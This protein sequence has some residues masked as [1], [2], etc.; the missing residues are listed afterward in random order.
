MHD[1]MG[2]SPE[3]VSFENL[4]GDT[5]LSYL[6]WLED[7]RKCSATTRNLRKTAISS[8]AKYAM[9]KNLGE[10]I[11]FYT[12][13]SDIPRK[14]TQ[15][16]PDIKYFTKEEVSILLD[17]PNTSTKIGRRN[18]VLMS[19]L[20]ASGARAQELCDITLNDVYFGS[21]TNIRLIGKGNKPRL[22]TIPSN[23]ASLLKKYLTNIG[24][25]AAN[26]N[27]Q[28]RHIFSSQTNDKMSP[29]CVG[30]IV[31]KYVGIVKA[32]H[33]HLFWRNKY[34]PHS[35]RHSIAVHMLECGE[36]LA[37]IKAFLGH[38]S[39]TS[40][41]I[42]ANVTPELAN[43]YLRERGKAIPEINVQ[44]RGSFTSLPF[45]NRAVKRPSSD[46]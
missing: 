38:A 30:E 1:K 11:A 45:L 35:F 5:V 20:Y 36:S 17:A 34:S 9:K 42:Y 25:D 16:E 18:A 29:S 3:K 46:S 24:L 32:S 28:R 26:P 39:I 8:F 13:V 21:E 40:T 41:T 31:K 37:V 23:C 44:Q 15:T 7:E 22:V 6:S 2:L 19:V 10:A 12:E 14:R 33:P 4:G 27:H 43:R